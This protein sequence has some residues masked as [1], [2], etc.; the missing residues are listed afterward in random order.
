MGE[1]LSTPK[2]DKD[3]EDGQCTWVSLNFNSSI[4]FSAQMGQFRNAGLAQVN[5]RRPY[6]SL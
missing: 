1:Y 4:T 5:G 3:S 6:N 2:K